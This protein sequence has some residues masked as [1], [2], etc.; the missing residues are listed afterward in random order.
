MPGPFR[1]ISQS[2]SHHL[3]SLHVLAPYMFLIL[4]SPSTTIG[5]EARI[6]VFAS[7]PLMGIAALMRSWPLK[8]TDSSV[9]PAQF[10]GMLTAR[11]C[12]RDAEGPLAGLLYVACSA[13]NWKSLKQLQQAILINNVLP[14]LMRWC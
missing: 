6:K 13:A 2:S 1:D 14:H 8:D 4:V 11:A 7:V 3:A 5:E 9:L 12:L 10:I